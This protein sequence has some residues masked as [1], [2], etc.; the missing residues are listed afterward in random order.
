MNRRNRKALEWLITYVSRRTKVRRM[1]VQ[2]TLCAIADL[3]WDFEG[4]EYDLMGLCLE[5]MLEDLGRQRKK[6]GGSK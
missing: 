1:S 5:E 2:K 3:E 6:K 4:T